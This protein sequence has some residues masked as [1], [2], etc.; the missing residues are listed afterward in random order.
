[1]S[2]NRW[3]SLVDGAVVFDDT[4]RDSVVNRLPL[5]EGSGTDVSDSV[6][7][8]DGT[9]V[10]G[11]DWTTDS[12]FFGGTAP[13]FDGG[14]EYGEWQP[15]T[16]APITWTMRVRLDALDTVQY[17]FGHDLFPGVNYRSDEE[18]W[19]GFD[20]D[21]FVV[22]VADGSSEVTSNIR[23]LALRLDGDNM[24]LDVWDS[25]GEKIGTDSDTNPSTTFDGSTT[26]FGDR[27]AGSLTID[28]NV[29]L[30]DVHDV[31]LSDSELSDVIQSV[32]Y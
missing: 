20:S 17:P 28:G 23:V 27:E 4:I 21:G 29:D 6:G 12:G 2:F 25:N 15:R 5:D 31:F 18:E 32:Y 30:F 8:A 11:G 3:R 26:Y 19:R 22:A 24:A 7:N 14:S 1:M 10:N 13:Y 16:Q 9:L